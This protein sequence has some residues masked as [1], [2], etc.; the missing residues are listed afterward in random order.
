MNKANS[1]RTALTAALPTLTTD[2]DKLLVF[3]DAGRVIA[4]DAPSLSFEYRF[5]L[6]AIL[7]D[8][9]GDADAVFVALLAWVK[10]NQPDLLSNETTRKDGISFEAEHLTNDTCDLS[11]KLQLSES[12]VVGA[13]DQGVQTIT[14]ID[15]PV[16]EWNL[17]SLIA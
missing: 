16:F 8:F 14:H 17:D 2:P 10:R 12:V 4:T 15:E 13:D 7:L 9:A 3:I 6:N 11:I 1:F 5:T